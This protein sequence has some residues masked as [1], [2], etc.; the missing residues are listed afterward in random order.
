MSQENV[1]IVRR[2][3]AALNERDVEGYLARCTDDIELVSP[4]AAIEGSSRG[5]E[6]IREFFA[7]LKEA[8]DVFDLSVV[9][10]EA[11]DDTRVLVFADLRFRSQGGV[12]LTQPIANL[13]DL[14]GGRLRRVQVFL[15]RAEALEAAGLRE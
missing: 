12:P 13:Y 15:D 6:G 5:P 7:G 1:E 8:A 2:V 11:V 9:R 14:T 3:I 10:I 4:I